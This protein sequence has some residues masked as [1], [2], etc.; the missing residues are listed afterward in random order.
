MQIEK[1]TGNG[2]IRLTVSGELT[3]AN[4]RPLQAELAECLGGAVPAVV[5]DLERIAEADLAGLQVLQAARRSFAARGGSLLI[6][7]GEEV[8]RMW[9]AAGYPRQEVS[10]GENHH[11]RG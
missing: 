7:D 11:D 1:Q 6:L 3:L 10:N 9:N 8:A 2:Q 4:L 5:L